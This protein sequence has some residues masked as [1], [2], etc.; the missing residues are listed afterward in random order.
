MTE[1]KFMNGSFIAEHLGI[2][3][4]AV[5]NWITREVLPENLAPDEWVQGNGPYPSPLWLRS[6]LGIFLLWFNERHPS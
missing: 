3:P 2:R 4:S 1:P 6:K 5:S